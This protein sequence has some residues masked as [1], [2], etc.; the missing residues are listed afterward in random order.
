MNVANLLTAAA[1]ERPDHPAFVFEGRTVT[2]RELERLT[3]QFANLLGQRGV[4]P[5][6]VI[7][8]FLESSPEL[9]V[10]YMGALRAGVVP[11]VVNASLKPE[12]VRLV[13]S[14]SNAFLLVTDPTRWQALQAVRDGLGTCQT[15][16]SGDDDVTED[17]D[18]GLESFNTALEGSPSDFKTLELAPETLASLLY[19][20]GT[21]GFAK[22]VMLSHRNIIDNATNFARVHFTADDR[23]LIAAPLF[24]CWGL[25]N[26]LL[27]SFVA[28]A[29]AI[30]PRRYRTEP[31]LDL[32]E[33]TRPRSCSAFRPWST[34]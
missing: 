25:I 15:L 14:D 24:H 28:R 16:L 7:A 32:I 8:I 34:T 20:S 2:Y 33:T 27:G 4:R 17:K 26:G 10:A 6:D 18:E 9:I 5:G 30:V 11:N 1:H 21:T 23:L 12:E 31:T 22:G 13:V 19:T 3:G 29:T